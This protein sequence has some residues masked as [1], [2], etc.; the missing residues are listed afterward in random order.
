M[1]RAACAAFPRK[2]CDRTALATLGVGGAPKVEVSKIRLPGAVRIGDELR[3]GFVVTSTT[4]R[5]QQLVVDYVVHFVKANGAA[6]PK[7]FKLK[8]LTL[9]GHTSVQLSGK[10]SFAQLT[11]SAAPSRCASRRTSHQWRC[12]RARQTRRANGR[13]W[14]AVAEWVG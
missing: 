5:K 1:D 12:P 2:A 13:P 10:V 6:R 7:V 3:F 9:D 4:K 11:T 8:R 14:G